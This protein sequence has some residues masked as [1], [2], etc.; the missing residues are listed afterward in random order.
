MKIETT[1]AKLIQA[2]RNYNIETLE[3]PENFDPIDDGK[4]CATLQADQ[5]LRHLYDLNN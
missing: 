5:L 2:L 1:R 3:Q 4:I